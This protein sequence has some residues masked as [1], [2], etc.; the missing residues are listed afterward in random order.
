MAETENRLRQTEADLRVFEL[1][2]EICSHAREPQEAAHS[3]LPRNGEL[4]VG[5]IIKTMSIPKANVSRHSFITH[6][7]L[8]N[9]YGIGIS[10]S[11]QSL[12]DTRKR[13]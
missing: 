13:L 5:E 2:S 6:R 9:V 3:Q 12:D 8:E 1:Q 7:Y 11:E 10:A 4:S